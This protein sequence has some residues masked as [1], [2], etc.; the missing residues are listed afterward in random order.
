[1]LEGGEVT[2]PLA[3]EA[4]ADGVVTDEEL[5]AVKQT[6]IDCL[7]AAGMNDITVNDDGS[8]GFQAPEGMM[9]EE[10]AQ[11]ETQCSSGGETGWFALVMTRYEVLHPPGLDGSVL[12]AECLVRVG[13][14]PEG[15]TAEDYDND[16]IDESFTFPGGLGNPKFWE[17]NNDPL[18]AQ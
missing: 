10:V 11:L 15:Y 14:E 13:L 12:M 1:M 3:V 17:C 8:Q 5:A 9:A 18:H 2:A 7:S 4:L 16:S 6:Y